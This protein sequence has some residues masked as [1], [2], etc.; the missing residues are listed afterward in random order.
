MNDANSLWRC[1]QHFCSIRAISIIGIGRG[2]TASPLPHHLAYGSRTKAVRSRLS[3]DVQPGYTKIIKAIGRRTGSGSGRRADAGPTCC[4]GDPVRVVRHPIVEY[5]KMIVLPRI[6]SASVAHHNADGC[7]LS[8]VQ[9]FG[10]RLQLKP[11]PGS[12]R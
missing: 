4:C 3:L 9:L 1:R 8:L 12:C 6:S 5:A 11:A 7:Q 10:R 2:L